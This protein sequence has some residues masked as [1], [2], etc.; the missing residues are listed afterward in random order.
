M[1]ENQT[2]L[3]PQEPS[4][5]LSY[6]KEDKKRVRAIYQRLRKERLNP[7]LDLADLLPGQDWDRT[8]ISAIRNAKFFLVFLSNNSINKR[9]YVQKEIREAL[10]VAERMPDGELFIIPVRLEECIVPDRLSKWH[11]IDIFRPHGLRKIVNTLRAKFDQVETDTLAQNYESEHVS[12]QEGKL[13]SGDEYNQ[14]MNEL[15]L[16]PTYKGR[17][18]ELR[19]LGLRDF[20]GLRRDDAPLDPF[21]LAHFAKLMVINFDEIKGL[22]REAREHLLGE[23]A[24]TWSGGTASRPLPNGWRLV[25]LNPKH[26]LQRNNATLM[27]EVCHVYL[28]HKANRLHIL[29]ENKQGKTVAREYNE[30][31]EEVA[32]AVGAAALVPFTALRRF[33]SKGEPS[34]AIAQHFNVSRDLIE[35]RIKV[36]RLWAEYKARHPE[37]FRR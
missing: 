4:I 9:G 28:G 33:V 29:A 17:Q 24:N 25:I 32:Y 14:F 36:S 26:G 23:G 3:K 13:I 8:I 18:Y 5:F 12:D 35:Y 37:E 20:A 16:P 34:R 7:W 2:Q 10:D 19:A 21:A 1:L 22:S 11:W 30:E 15:V 31:D 6:A 27:E